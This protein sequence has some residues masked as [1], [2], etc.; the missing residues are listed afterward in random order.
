MHHLQIWALK[1]KKLTK[2]ER[3]DALWAYVS[4]RENGLKAEK[5]LLDEDKAEFADLN[6]KAAPKKV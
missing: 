4:M 5:E 6:I 2:S 3:E 1:D